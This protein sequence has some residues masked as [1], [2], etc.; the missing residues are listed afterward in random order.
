MEQALKNQLVQKNV[1]V[2]TTLPRCKRQEMRIL[3]VEEQEKFLNAI[4]NHRNST[5][6]TMSLACGL[7]QGE[8]LGLRWR[9]VDVKQ[10]IIH[11]RQSLQRV[12]SY[13]SG[14]TAKTKLEYGEP[15]SERSKRSIPIPTDVLKE[16]LEY[17]KRQMEEKLLLGQAYQDN[18]LV[19]CIMNGKPYDPRSFNYIFKRLVKK[20]GIPDANLH[21]L[22]H[23][24]ATRLLESNVHPKVV[25][26]L[27]GHSNI[28]TTLDTYSHVMP[29][30]KEAAAQSIN[31]LFIRKS[32]S[33]KEGKIG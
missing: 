15:K 17:R 33:S 32:P 24:F 29:E 31:H 26:E 14:S 7:R 30:I 4:Q 8:I 13:D 6:L 3:T 10:G 11:I 5:A 18:D 1:S 19:F 28:T 12:K 27:L 16:L 9:D 22:R 25:Q 23:T 2:A 21:A 20:A